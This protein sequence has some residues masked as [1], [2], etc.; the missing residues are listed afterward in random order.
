MKGNRE[1]KLRL[2]ICGVLTALL[3]LGYMLTPAHA[4]ANSDPNKT[5]VLYTSYNEP[6]DWAYE[7]VRESIRQGFVPEE[8]YPLDFHKAISREDFSSLIVKVY[9]KATGSEVRVRAT[10]Q[11][12]DDEYVEK[13]AG[14]GI[15]T[16]VGTN[17][18]NPDGSLTREQ[19]ATII[20]RLLTTLDHSFKEPS[21][22]LYADINIVSNWAKDSVQQLKAEGILEGVGA[23]KFA[24]QGNYTTEQAIVTVLRAY[25]HLNK[26]KMQAVLSDDYIKTQ[27][28]SLKSK[29][30]TGTP[31]TNDSYY[32]WRG[33]IYS[34][35]Y[36][37][38]G[39]AFML[40]DKAFGELPARKHTNY[41]D[42]RL[43][44][45]VRVNDDTHSVI[46]IDIQGNEYTLA[47]G[48]YGRTVN[49]GRK[50]THTELKAMGTHILTRY[51]E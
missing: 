44:D 4:A 43:G 3:I 23:N 40:S 39:F 2:L 18:F 28:L 38:A 48:N 13:A 27:L 50:V 7:A 42:I 37:C 8:K 35:G 12:T 29:Y 45:V 51:P 36:G 41:E 5:K 33:G 19:A 26:V 11:D 32:E 14:L 25:N 16:G 49:W 31:W 20:D 46:I 1:F 21:T 10:F 24:P 6:S 17:N 47:E 15:V 22:E 9:E 34:G 30:P